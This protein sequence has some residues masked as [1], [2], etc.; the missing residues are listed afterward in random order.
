[1]YYSRIGNLDIRNSEYRLTAIQPSH[2]EEI[3]IWRNSQRSVLRQKETISKAN[4]IKYFS[5]NIWPEFTS[6]KPS[7]ILFSIYSHDKLVAYGGLVHISWEDKRAEVSFLCAPYVTNSLFEYGEIF[8]FFLNTVKNIAFSM[9]NFNRL[10]TETFDIR[11]HHVSILEN[12]KFEFEGR[13][14]KHNIIDGTT[15]D[16]LLHGCVNESCR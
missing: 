6:N 7:Q 2:I 14:V 16:S 4:Q 5:E 8:G 9:L 12:N 1:M 3:R 15:V 13:L 11:P 10:F